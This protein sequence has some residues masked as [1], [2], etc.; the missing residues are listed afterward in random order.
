MSS[1]HTM[2]NRLR[3]AFVCLPTP[4]QRSCS[5]EGPMQLLEM[6]KSVPRV[7][8]V[9]KDLFSFLRRLICGMWPGGG[10]VTVQSTT[11]Q[12]TYVTLSIVLSPT[13][14]GPF[15]SQHGQ[16]G[17]LLGSRFN[18]SMVRAHQVASNACRLL[19]KYQSN[20]VLFPGLGTVPLHRPRPT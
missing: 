19:E 20:V 16:L 15:S 6:D 12:S 18:S 11:W 3:T 17:R 9:Q 10:R 1:C 8:S 4:Q 2:S 7:F 14:C 13:G 5:E